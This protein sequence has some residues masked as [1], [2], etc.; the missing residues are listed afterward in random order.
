MTTPVPAASNR[1]ADVP[2]V[3]PGTPRAIAVTRNQM[4][5]LDL[6]VSESPWG[7]D[8]TRARQMITGEIV[9]ANIGGDAPSAEEIGT[10]IGEPVTIMSADTDSPGTATYRLNRDRTW[11]RKCRWANGHQDYCPAQPVPDHPLPADTVEVLGLDPSGCHA[12]DRWPY[13][14]S[15][16]TDD[17][18]DRV[19]AL[20]G[21][22]IGIPCPACGRLIDQTP[23]PDCP[24]CGRYGFR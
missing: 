20:P 9:I 7:T 17:E 11:C 6:L 13:R 1:P 4:A 8:A 12:D 21:P 2:D 19:T 23:N 14:W 22:E 3:D 10:A 15:N 24:L 18:R 16:L 5:V